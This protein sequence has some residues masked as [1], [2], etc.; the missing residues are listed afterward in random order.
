MQMITR[1]KG[2]QRLVRIGRIAHDS[3]E[4]EHL[5]IGFAGPALMNEALNA[6]VFVAS[7]YRRPIV[8]WMSDLDAM[9]SSDARESACYV[10][11]LR[12]HAQRRQRVA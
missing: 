7:P 6:T 11:D 12:R 9:T 10:G 2:R 1:V 5:V 3:V 4:I 8:G